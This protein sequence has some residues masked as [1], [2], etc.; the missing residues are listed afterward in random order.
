MLNMATFVHRERPEAG[1]TEIYQLQLT[2]PPVMTNLELK[3]CIT[4]KCHSFYSNNNFNNIGLQRFA[5][6]IIADQGTGEL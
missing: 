3:I 1:N 5:K 4:F 6:D 2:A